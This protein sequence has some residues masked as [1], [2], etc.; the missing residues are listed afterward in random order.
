MA[1]W[2][3]AIVARLRPAQKLL[4][5]G[6]DIGAGMAALAVAQHFRA[7]VYCMCSTQ[8][9]KETILDKFPS[10]KQENIYLER[11]QVEKMVD[12]MTD[13]IV[14]DV[15]LD[16]SPDK[17]ESVTSDLLETNGLLVKLRTSGNSQ[18]FSPL[19]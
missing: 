13:G 9:K 16:C 18:V 1:Y 17:G 3:L 5:H 14:M 2:A 11:D 4:V 6:A 7:Q 15:V 8:G 12:L 10:L 19:N